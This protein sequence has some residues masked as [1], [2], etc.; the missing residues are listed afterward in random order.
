MGSFSWYKDGILY[1]MGQAMFWY[2]DFH[3]KNIVL[4]GSDLIV[5]MPVGWKYPDPNML[6]TMRRA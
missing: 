6:V 3:C 4:A 2:A 5:L 1:F